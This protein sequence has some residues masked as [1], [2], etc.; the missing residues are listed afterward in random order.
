M[1]AHVWD[2]DHK[3]I[4]TGTKSH[5]IMDIETYNVMLFLMLLHVVCR[6]PRRLHVGLYGIIAY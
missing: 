5:R 1:L 4:S 6:I 2:A 3:I